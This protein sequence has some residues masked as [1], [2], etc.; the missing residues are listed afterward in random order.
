MKSLSNPK[1]F[2]IRLSSIGDI[3]LT[4]ALIRMIRNSHPEHELYYITDDKYSSILRYNRHLNGIIVY[5]K[6]MNV[7]ETINFGRQ[8]NPE[9]TENDFVIDLHNNLRT[10]LIKFFLKAKKV[11][12]S[13]NRIFKLALTTFQKNISGNHLSIP[14]LYFDT[15]SKVLKLND[16]GLGLE[17]WLES[18]KAAG[19]YLPHERQQSVSDTPKITIA[20]GATYFTKRWLPENFLMAA[21]LLNKKFNA[22]ISLVGGDSDIELCQYIEENFKQGAISNHAGKLDLVQSATIVRESDLL[23]TNDTGMMHIAA[24]MQTPVV[25]IFG[26]S[27]KDLGFVPYRTPSVVIESELDCRPC[28]HIGRNSCPKGHF[29]CMKSILPAHVVTNIAQLLQI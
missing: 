9:M 4:T 22:E 23:L 10:S 17:F 26:S 7:A 11:S 12:V 8:L 29:N 14:Q 18:D 19:K 2:L 20:P 27:V 24:A 13:K 15:A 28:S 1:I 16:D 5:N 21:Q 6:S 25:A 3:I